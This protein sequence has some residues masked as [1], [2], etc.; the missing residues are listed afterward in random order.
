VE[1]LV[2]TLANE[3]KYDFFSIQFASGGVGTGSSLA[4]Y[5]TSSASSGTPFPEWVYSTYTQQG[6]DMRVDTVLIKDMKKNKDLRFATSIDTGYYSAVLTPTNAATRTFILRNIVTKFLEKDNTNAKI[7]SWNDFPR[8]FP[9]L[10]DADVYLLYAEA[11]VKNGK[12]ALAKQYVDKI[13][14]RAGLA[15]LAANPTLD[16]IKLERKY[17]FIGEGKRYFDLVRWGETEAIGTLTASAV[18]YHSLL[19][20]QQPTKKDLL[21]PIPQNELKTRT[22]WSQNFGY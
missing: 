19:N 13:R 9:I 8:N 6:Q 14:T 1:L 7:K 2:I 15:V 17:E 21:L 10:R 16:D 18:R 3:N 22:N 5:V 12:A 11:L 4:G 20:G